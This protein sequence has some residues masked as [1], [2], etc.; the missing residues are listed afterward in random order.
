MTTRAMDVA[1][2]QFFGCGR[3]YFHNFNLKEKIDPGEWMI[4]VDRYSV[5]FYFGHRHGFAAVSTK[6][7]TGAYILSTE[8]VFGYLLNELGILLPIAFIRKHLDIELVALFLA[9]KAFFHAGD[10][11]AN[12]LNVVKWIATFT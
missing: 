3:A 6:A 8:C 10:E 9:L 2:L 12:T 5:L 7:H 11:I 1:V 4:S